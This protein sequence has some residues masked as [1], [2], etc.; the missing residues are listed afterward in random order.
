[1]A[2]FIRASTNCSISLWPSFCPQIAK[3][4]SHLQSHNIKLP[5]PPGDTSEQALGLRLPPW[6]SCCRAA[7]CGQG[8]RKA[9]HTREQT[10]THQ[11]KPS[12]FHNS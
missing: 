12:S 11:C 1:M 9:A 7:K 6:P 8:T 5:L 10:S 2:D 4:T 3:Q